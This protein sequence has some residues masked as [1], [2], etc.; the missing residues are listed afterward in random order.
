MVIFFLIA[1]LLCFGT[2]TV[3]AR[4]T[5]LKVAS[6]APDG[7][8][9]A[10]RF[11]EFAN[12]VREKSN[13]EVT[14]KSYPGGVMGDDR[15][16]YRKM[17]VGQLHGGGFTMVGLGDVVPDFRVLGIPFLFNSYEEVDQ[18]WER[19]RPRLKKAFNEKNMILLAISEVGFVYTLSTS[20]IA[21]IEDLQKGKCWVPE[22]DPISGVFLKTAG[23]NATPLSIPDVLSSLQTGLVDTVFNGF[24]GAIALQWFTRAKYIS[25]VPF[26]YSYGA[27]VV[28]KKAFLRLSP[29]NQVLIENTADKYISNLMKAD[30]RRSNT[31]ALELLLQN[32]ISLIKVDR[33][34]IVRLEKYRDETV[35][36]LTGEAFS[37]SIYEETVNYLNEIRSEND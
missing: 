18:V 35:A 34:E 36:E 3:A 22:G 21:T 8:V 14:F 29:E 7:S 6:L 20:P 4:S 17:R 30:T 26:V 2:E 16:M 19:L 25:D 32:N 10:K 15:A 28:D 11:T 1:G 9:W 5:V 12:E 33:K 23:V 27:L 31:E 13:N 37:K 24:Y